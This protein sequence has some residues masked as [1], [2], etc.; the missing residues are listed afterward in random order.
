[1]ACEMTTRSGAP[2]SRAAVYAVESLIDGQLTRR[3]CC[4][5]HRPDV[6]QKIT[7]DDPSHFGHGKRRRERDEFINIHL[8]VSGIGAKTTSSPIEEHIHV[9]SVAFGPITEIEHLNREYDEYF[10]EYSLIGAYNL[11][12]KEDYR[13]PMWLSKY[14]LCKFRMA[15][16]EHQIQAL[17]RCI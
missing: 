10:E 5:Q 13:Y 11:Q 3:C 8:V 15:E 14:E 16:I 17:E 2:C 9:G 4:T 7:F 1:M 12:D 6:I